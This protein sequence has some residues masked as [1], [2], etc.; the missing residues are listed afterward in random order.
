MAL[1]LK[2]RGHHLLCLQGFQG[3]GYN[4]R[5]T[6]NMAAVI[7]Q[8]ETD[9]ELN[10]EIITTED[11]I[12]LHCP[13]LSE[14]G[15]RKETGSHQKIRSLDLKVLAKLNCQPGRKENA[16]QIIKLTNNM[17][18]TY[19]DIREICG[20]CHWKEQCLWFQRF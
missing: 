19:A 15:C 6:E 5:F 10:L 20:N 18:K 13:C 1:T 9:P 12:C 2:I 11:D 17:F 4:L 16:Q 3:Y 14:T 8:I 7:R